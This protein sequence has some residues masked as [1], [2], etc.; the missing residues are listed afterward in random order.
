M[1]EYSVRETA[2]ERIQ[3]LSRPL[4]LPGC[5]AICGFNGT[6]AS[7]LTDQRIFVDFN[8][9]VDYYGRIYWCSTCFLQG[10]NNLGW[11]S[12]DQ[13]E[14]LRAKI[15]VLESERI[16]LLEQNERLRASLS[17]LL[18][19]SDDPSI[20]VLLG[21][22]ENERRQGEDS[23]GAVGDSEQPESSLDESSSVEGFSSVSADSRGDN[24]EQFEFKL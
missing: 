16:V 23:D 9:D 20:S 17:S 18:G 24:P 2:G 22:S 10:A 8:L 6:N 14:Q 1:T 11:L 21:D 4:A 13:A 15:S 5:C 12:V 19:R 3:I 7:D